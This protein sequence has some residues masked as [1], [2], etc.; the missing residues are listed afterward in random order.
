M[1]KKVAISLFLI[2]ALILPMSI[3]VVHA[4]HQHDS[5]ICLAIDESH[6]HAEK[7]DCEQLHYFSQT[8]NDGGIVIFDIATSRLFVQ[9][10]YYTNFT[11][12]QSFSKADPD[13][14]PPAINV[15]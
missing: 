5:N 13:R 2:L 14:G 15:S 10:E 3:S 12:I 9:N 7:T 4:F 11:L 8:L 6:F 1:N